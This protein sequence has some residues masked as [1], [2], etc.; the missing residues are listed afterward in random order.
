[1]TRRSF[2]QRVAE[3]LAATLERFATTSYAQEGEDRILWRIFEGEPAGFYVDVGAHHPTRFSN[4]Y[5]FY[6]EGW[7]GLT[8]DADPGAAPLFARRRPRDTHVCVGVSDAPGR[9]MYYRFDESALNTFDADLAAQRAKIGRYRALP[10]ITVE[11]T[12]LAAQ[13]HR[14]VRAGQE[15][16]FL[17]VDVEGYD[18]RVLRSGD[19]Q[20]YRPRYVLAES[21]GASLATLSSDECCLFMRSVGYE[22]FAKTSRTV[23]YRRL[24][25]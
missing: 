7:R 14:H 1:M 15:I 21:L 9:L 11:L 8:I 19:W 12:T 20:A 2:P 22:P 25:T 3:R 16:A 18:A 24:G 6:R 10:G 5:L 4:T 23:I 17:S 13:M